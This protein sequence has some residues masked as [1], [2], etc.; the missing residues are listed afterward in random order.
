METGCGGGR[1]ARRRFDELMKDAAIAKSGPIAAEL[2]PMVRDRTQPNQNVI[3]IRVQPG[4]ERLRV[5]AFL[6][7]ENVVGVDDQG[8]IDLRSFAQPRQ[9]SRSI[10]GEI[11]PRFFEHL[12]WQTILV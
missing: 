12:T 11:L 2:W 5:E 8:V 1:R 9:G 4:L 7:D 10:V 3:K 6:A